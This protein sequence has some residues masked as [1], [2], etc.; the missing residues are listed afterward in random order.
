MIE[1]EEITLMRAKIGKLVEEGKLHASTGPELYD[2][3]TEEEKRDL[4]AALA[5]V[6]G[7]NKEK[8]DDND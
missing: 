1:S 2:D 5:D 3:W 6:F 7:W 4:K 8:S